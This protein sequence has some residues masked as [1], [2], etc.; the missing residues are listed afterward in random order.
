MFVQLFEGW[1]YLPGARDRLVALGLGDAPT[2]GVRPDVPGLMARLL[3]TSPDDPDTGIGLW[4]WESEAACR[5]YEE[6][7]PAAVQANL[8][9]DLDDTAVVERTFDALLFARRVS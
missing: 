1:R 6:N 5:A 8:E 2:D 3:A 9:R 7:R 4:V